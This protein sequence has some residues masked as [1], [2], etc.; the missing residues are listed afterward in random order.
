MLVLPTNSCHM[1]HKASKAVCTHL[2]VLKC[3]FNVTFILVNNM[4]FSDDSNLFPVCY[5]S[6]V[7]QAQV[8]HLPFSWHVKDENLACGLCYTSG[9]TGSPKVRC[10]TGYK[11]FYKLW[12]I[13]IIWFQCSHNTLT[14]H[15]AIHY[16]M[17]KLVRSQLINQQ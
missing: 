16:C 12:S 5:K 9:T 3:F 13:T 7:L 2:C 10:R 4:K 15:L 1:F 6:C 17:S 8:K 11:A 14:T